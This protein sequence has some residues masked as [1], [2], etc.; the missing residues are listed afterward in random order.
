[1]MCNCAYCQEGMSKT[2]EECVDRMVEVTKRLREHLK[3]KWYKDLIKD[4]QRENNLDEIR[5][6]EKK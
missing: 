1:M 5:L 3:A 2:A 4:S 6:E